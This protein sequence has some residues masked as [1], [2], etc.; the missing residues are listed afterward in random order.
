MLCGRLWV[1]AVLR[2]KP[3]IS[4]PEAFQTPLRATPAS[5]QYR[6]EASAQ[7]NNSSG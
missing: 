6:P 3:L 2:A 1:L 4:L 7:S 5:F